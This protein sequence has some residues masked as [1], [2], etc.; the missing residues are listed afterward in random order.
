MQIEMEGRDS[1]RMVS[2][3]KGTDGDESENMADLR[4]VIAEQAN[5]IAQLR[6]T[7]DSGKFQ[8]RTA[9]KG[10]NLRKGRMSKLS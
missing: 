9:W 8:R 10:Q 2:G 4:R 6:R 1:E 5:T 7:Q 3:G